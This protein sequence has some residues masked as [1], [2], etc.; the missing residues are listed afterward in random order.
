[1]NCRTADITCIIFALLLTL[2]E[3]PEKVRQVK[4]VK[5]R[6]ERHAS[7]YIRLHGHLEVV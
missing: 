5:K 3:H 2:D 7:W 6:E 4:V 1:M